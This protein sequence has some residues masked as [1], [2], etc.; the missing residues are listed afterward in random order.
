METAIP[1]KTTKSWT[2]YNPIIVHRE[3]W[4]RLR[5]LTACKYS[6]PLIIRSI[7]EEVGPDYPGPPRGKPVLEVTLKK[8]PPN[9]KMKILEAK[10]LFDGDNDDDDDNNNNNNNNNNIVLNN[11]VITGNT[12]LYLTQI[13]PD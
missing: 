13:F 7:W 1:T 10:T 8:S 3:F 11:S 4:N 6:S 12:G 9:I 5:Q 2:V